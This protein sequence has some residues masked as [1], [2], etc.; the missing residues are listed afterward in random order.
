[1]IIDLNKTAD[2]PAKK[3]DVVVIG[4]GPSGLSVAKEL[5]NT[6][7]TVAVLESGKTKV[8]E[9]HDRLRN[10]VSEGIT[11][12]E[13]S[14]ER[15]LGGASTTWSGLSSPLDAI[16]Y[17]KRTFVKHSGW[18]VSAGE[19]E[20]YY[21]KA[22][23]RYHFPERD[24]YREGGF[25]KVKMKSELQLEL[26]DIDE[27]IFL[28]KEDALD[29]GSAL[30]N[31]FAGER[32][33]LYLDATAVKLIKS[34]KEGS[35]DA[36]EIV[37]SSMLRR[38]VEAGAFVVAAGGI[39][40]PRLLLHSDIGN[41]NDQVGRFM[42]NHPKNNFGIIKLKKQVAESPYYFGCMVEGNAGYAGL[43]LSE[44]VQE[45]KK[46]LNS[47]VRFEPLFPWTDN[48]GVEALIALV[49]NAK[50]IMTNFNKLNRGKVVSLRDYSETGDDSEL[51]SGRKGRLYWLRLLWYIVSNPV[52]VFSYLYFRVVPGAAPGIKRVR[53]RN[54]MEMEPSPVN[55]VTLG[56][57]V[58]D[59]GVPVPVV[60]HTPSE[61]DKYSLKELHRVLKEEIKKS[62][63][64]QLA[65]DLDSIDPWPVDQ[66]ASHHLGTTRMGENPETSVVDSNCRVHG[67]ENVFMAGGSV[68]P[69]S[70]CVNPTYTMVALAIRLA[71]HLKSEVFNSSEGGDQ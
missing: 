31:L 29:F 39:E 53:L 52:P 59:Y 51:Q 30:K 14:R 8:T 45:R 27:K 6:G 46:V 63:I 71:D 5:H 3:Y 32:L 24:L 18:P 28:A 56:S 54:F 35:V 70:S 22:S 57:E 7:L 4:A 10:V 61:L 68:F 20:P 47:Y 41:K 50:V 60:A 23:A 15:V 44:D 34:E 37:T 2:V 17:K 66:D 69:T 12:K 67:V 16:D 11:I 26:A 1:M 62:G 55:R 38:Q 48:R 36:V 25:R 13:H 49:K 42:M 19:L 21:E 64:G 65:S 33:D 9:F 43:R 40:N 58:D